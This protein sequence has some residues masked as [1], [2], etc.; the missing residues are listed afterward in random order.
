MIELGKVKTIEDVPFNKFHVKMF[1]FT[2]GS[3]LIDGYAIGMIAIALS[4]LQPQFEMSA[5]MA[6]LVGASTLIGMFIG[7]TVFGYITDLVGRK[8]MFIIDLVVVIVVSVLQFYAADVVQ[9]L[10]LRLI[11]GIALGADYP[12]AG[13]LMA[14]FSPR[15]Q[16]GALLG[17]LVG[18][19]FVGYSVSYLF[20]YLMIPIGDTSWRWMLASVAIPSF[21]LLL[22][23][24]GMP[25]SPMW[26]ASKGRIDEAKKIIREIFGPGISLAEEPQGKEKSSYLDMFRNGYAKWTIFVAVFWTLQVAPMFAIAT[27]I[28]EIIS[29]FGFGDGNKEYLGSAIINMFYLAGLIPALYLVE[30]IGRRAVLIWPFLVCA[31]SVGLLAIFS[32]GGIPFTVMLIMFIIYGVANTGM[33]ILQWIYPNEL[34]P[35]KIR[36]TAMGFGSGISRIGAAV[37]TFLFPIFMSNYGLGATLWLCAGLFLLGFVISIILAP[38]TKGLSLAEASSLNEKSENEKTKTNPTIVVRKV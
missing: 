5:L 32:D 11:L 3:A 8:K 6:G 33:G 22:G 35:T 1:T 13:A 27:F 19:W 28:P 2:G 37:S 10:I 30:R 36:A 15:K 17:G 31:L 25:E 16:R 7:G 23:R 29:Q 34:F 26:L 21:F 20:G 9:L 12:I 24:I 4:I 38:E 18:L 14:E